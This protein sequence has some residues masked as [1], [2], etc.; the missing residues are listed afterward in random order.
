MYKYR[1]RLDLKLESCGVLLYRIERL[2]N[3]EL[4]GYIQS[5]HNLSQQGDAW[6]Y[7]NAKVFDSA[8][9][10]G[11]AKVYD[12]A[13][14]YGNAWIF[15]NAQVCG[16]AWVWG[17]AKVYDNAWVGGN[18]QVCGNAR[19]YGNAQVEKSDE[20]LNIIMKPFSITVTPDNIAIGCELKRRSEW[21]K[22]TEA[23]AEKMGLPADRYNTYKNAVK[24]AMKA[25]PK[26]SKK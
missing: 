2:S 12:D 25:V 15:G 19:V 3:N 4:G 26:R 20:I 21:L 9:V 16:N 10:W 17:D 14:V 6:V 11:N 8:R 7:D 22:V 1:L 23:E 18:A 13:Q 5:E 24:F